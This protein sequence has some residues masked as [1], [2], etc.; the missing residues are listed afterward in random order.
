MLEG[1]IGASA[2]GLRSDSWVVHGVRARECA[3][4]DAMETTDEEDEAESNPRTQKPTNP[5][6][7]FG[8]NWGQQGH[9]SQVEVSLREE[10][11]NGCQGMRIRQILSIYNCDLVECDNKEGKV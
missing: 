2:W 1:A 7:F 5:Q 8:S 10:D 4:A 9:C 11:E 3:T 6:K